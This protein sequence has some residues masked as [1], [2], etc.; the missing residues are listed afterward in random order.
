[1][2]EALGVPREAIVA[3]YLVTGE[4]L[5]DDIRFVVDMARQQAGMEIGTYDPVVDEALACLFGTKE[6]YIETFYQAVA[7]KYGSMDGYIRD[8][9]RFTDEMREKLRR[10]YLA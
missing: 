10:K 8:G 3:D 2:E 9:L 4:Y 1:M 5:R 7:E 6:E